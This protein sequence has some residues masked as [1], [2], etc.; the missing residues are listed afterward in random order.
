[1]AKTF[2]ESE[3]AQRERTRKGAT[4]LYRVRRMDA[5]EAYGGRCVWCGTIDY[6][7]FMVV[8]AGGFVWREGVPDPPPQGAR[9]KYA[10]LARHSYPEG[11]TLVCSSVC[12]ARLLRNR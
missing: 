4:T 2:E 5:I 9:N 10:W 11:F 1:M 8:P 12:R 3:Q 7:N 6:P